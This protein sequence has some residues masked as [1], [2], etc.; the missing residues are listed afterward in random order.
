MGQRIKARRL[1]AGLSACELARRIGVSRTAV[2]RW[3][4]G[5]R[6]ITLAHLAAI[7]KA[8]GCRI[9]ALV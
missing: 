4:Y 8:L 1:R 5:D 7:A 2:G 6:A 3:E 9:G